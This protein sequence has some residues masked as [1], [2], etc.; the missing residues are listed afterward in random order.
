[1]FAG[2]GAIPLEAA[3]LGCET[4]AVEL[5]PVAHLIELGTLTFLQR[6]GTTLADDVE[7]WGR[8]ILSE[9]CAQVSDLMGRFPKINL[10]KR[11]QRNLSY[12][13]ED[14][15]LSETSENLSIVAYYWTRTAPCPK[16][17]C[18]ATVPLYRQTW[19]RKK[20]SGFVAL[21]PEPDRKK[22][23]RSSG[24]ARKSQ[25]AVQCREKQGGAIPRFAETYPQQDLTAVK[26]I[27]FAK[28]ALNRI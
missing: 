12:S 1:M 23:L 7:K 8:S 11:N 9:V 4:Y 20:E 19:L 3:R 25:S 16:P 15:K 18:R 17:S 2:D 13:A 14:G 21:K 10:S 28:L 26:G 24:N 6:Y 27:R 5:N 22:K